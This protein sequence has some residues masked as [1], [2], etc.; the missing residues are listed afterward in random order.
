TALDF[1]FNIHTDIGLRTRGTRVNGKLVPL[2]HELKSGDQVEV[3]TSQNQKPTANWLEYVTTSRAKNKIRNVLNENIKKIAEEGKEILE[4]K[5]RHL[6]IT[7]NEKTVNELVVFF[8]LKTSLDLFYRMGIGTINNQQL[9]DFVAQKNST[10]LNFFK[11]I[12]RSPSANPEE[13]QKDEISK[14]Y[15]LLVFGPE[16]EKLD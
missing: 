6:K 9:K 12:K 13:I 3:I 1:A 2:D 14:N 16:E 5:L 11:K 4:R 7:L 10:F 8:K 15:D